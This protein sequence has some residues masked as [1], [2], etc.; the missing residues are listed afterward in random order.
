MINQTTVIAILAVVF[1]IGFYSR[2]VIC[3]HEPALTHWEILI[4]SVV[5]FFLFGYLPSNG[6]YY[7][8]IQAE[9]RVDWFFMWGVLIPVFF[10]GFYTRP[11]LKRLC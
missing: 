8:M 7:A 3:R 2:I 10:S 6:V 11:N 9:E 5:G 1:F 4:S